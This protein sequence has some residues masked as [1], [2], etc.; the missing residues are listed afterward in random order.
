MNEIPSG[1]RRL[2]GFIDDVYDVE[3]S[4][5]KT[6]F[7]E[8]FK[9]LDRNAHRGVALWRTT[10]PLAPEQLVRFRDRLIVVQRA[11]H[12]VPITIFGID[13]ANVGFAVLST[14]DGR[15]INAPVSAAVEVERRLL[16]MLAIV[17]HLHDNKVVC[18]DL[19]RESFL[20]GRDGTVSLF[21]VLGALEITAPD[22]EACQPAVRRYLAPR[23]DEAVVP[24][25][26]D[27]VFSLLVLAEDLYSSIRITG[28]GAGSKG[29]AVPRWMEEVLRVAQEA[30]VAG[31]QVTIRQLRADLERAKIEAADQAET[32]EVVASP[33]E[34]S[35]MGREFSKKNRTRGA[36]GRINKATSLGGAQERKLLVTVGVGRAAI[37]AAVF[38]GLVDYQGRAV[39]DSKARHASKNEEMQHVVPWRDSDESAAHAH[40]VKVLVNATDPEDRALVSKAIANRSRRYGLFRASDMVAQRYRSLGEQSSFGH[41]GESKVLLNVLDPSMDAATRNGEFLRLFEQSP[42]AAVVMAVAFAL[43]SGD[44]TTVR[45]LLARY[46]GDGGRA[47]E[48]GQRSALALMLYISETSQRYSEDF[49]DESDKV[50]SADILWLLKELARTGRPEVT[51]LAQVAHSRKLVSGAQ[52]VFLEELRQGTTLPVTLRSAL[53][54]GA[55]GSLSQDAVS[56]FGQWYGAGSARVL[57][58]SILTSDDEVL[59]RGAFELLRGKPIADSYIANLLEYIQGSYAE[60][61]HRFGTLLAAVALRDAIGGDVMVRELA[62]LDRASDAKSLLPHIIKGAPYE[63][64]EVVVPRYSEMIQPIDLIDILQHHDKRARMLALTYLS[65][66]NDI[67]LVKLIT[68]AYDDETDAEVR[69]AY[70]THI[71]TIRDRVGS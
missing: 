69:K 24:T 2:P 23:G 68:Q 14:F 43:D 65:A 9:A 53:V 5:A 25:A 71:S 66:V 46:V 51:M 64:L 57:E 67:L 33:D 21:G 4:I 49:V 45:D 8:A 44:L 61:A 41:D 47:T 7:A 16:S 30:I 15:P 55:L 48:I 22:R 17:E 37:A 70:E 34:E 56:V 27:D 32:P 35:E 54:A 39:S 12:V 60:N 62:A 58:A 13:S 1:F 6:V 28:A 10:K 19:C 3:T 11:P 18:G 42:Q 50:S 40:L 20:I 29:V 31:Q 63:V 36:K 59:R 38:A 26:Q 52:N